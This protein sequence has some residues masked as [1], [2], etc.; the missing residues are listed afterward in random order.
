MPCDQ[1]NQMVRETIW[2]GETFV[3]IPDYVNPYPILH[4]PDSPKISCYTK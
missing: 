3:S 2:I 4:K 1:K